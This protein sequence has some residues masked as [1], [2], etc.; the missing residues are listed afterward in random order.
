M[1]GERSVSA[2]SVHPSQTYRVRL[3]VLPGTFMNIVSYEDVVCLVYIYMV[4]CAVNVLNIWV[5]CTRTSVMKST[6]FLILLLL[7]YYYY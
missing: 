6:V 3:P 1:Q 2:I 4:D 7:Y 5:L